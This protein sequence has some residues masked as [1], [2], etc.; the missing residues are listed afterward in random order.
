MIANSCQTSIAKPP[1]SPNFLAGIPQ[2]IVNLCS[3]IEKPEPQVGSP[4][5]AYP[6]TIAFCLRRVMDVLGV[7]SPATDAGGST[8]LP[9]VKGN[10]EF[11]DVHFAYAGRQDLP[12]LSGMSLKVPAGSSMALV[13]SSGSGKSTAVALLL[14]LYEPSSGA[15]QYPVLQTPPIVRCPYNQDPHILLIS[16][17]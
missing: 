8:R 2:H 17:C 13:G 15:P 1:L 4:S 12:V 16:C 11:K 7:T 5:P 3:A 9:N 10:L 14:R 6:P